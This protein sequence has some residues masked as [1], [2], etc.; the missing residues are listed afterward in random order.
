MKKRLLTCTLIFSSLTF[1]G[2]ALAAGEVIGVS[3]AVK[4]KVTIKDD[5]Q[6][7]RDAIIKDKVRI[8]EEVNSRQ[9]S[10]LQVLLNDQT[11]FTVGPDCILTID[12]YVYD[13]SKVSGGMR[14][15]VKRGMFRFMSGNIAKSS[16]DVSIDTPVASMGVRGTIV[17][18]LVGKEAIDIAR[19]AGLLRPNMTLDQGGATLFILRGPGVNNQS[20]N[21]RGVIDVTSA[22][23]TVTINQS[24]MATF[25]SSAGDP[26]IAPVMLSDDI[27][28]AFSKRLRTKPP[29]NQNF[30]RPDTQTYDPAR[31]MDWPGDV[32]ISN[33]P[34]PDPGNEP[35]CIQNPNDPSCK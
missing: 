23:Q 25:V 8:G 6:I 2:S 26:P 19:R 13:P 22:G 29:R 14:A 18:G 24:G 33:D 1:A 17:E 3:S 30:E 21:R 31:D 7:I 27:Y 16:R 5:V 28:E 4:G 34:S 15:K 35:D 9:E 32:F 12:K 10:T 20:N 11:V